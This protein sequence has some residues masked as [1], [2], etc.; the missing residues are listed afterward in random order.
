MGCGDGLGGEAG[1]QSCLLVAYMVVVFCLGSAHCPMV[2]ACGH[3]PSSSARARG[4][5]QGQGTRHPG[6]CGRWPW[7]RMSKL[8]ARGPS[9]GCLHRAGADPTPSSGQSPSLGLGHCPLQSGRVLSQFV[10]RRPIPGSCEG[11]E[12]AHRHLDGRH[13]CHGLGNGAPDRNQFLLGLI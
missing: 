7:N 12:P 6:L 10:V 1:R 11:T 4:E 8:L 2:E 5:G 3:G 9:L 13:N